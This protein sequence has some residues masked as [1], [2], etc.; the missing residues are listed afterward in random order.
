LTTVAQA[1]EED[2]AEIAQGLP[3]GLLASALSLAG[4]TIVRSNLLDDLRAVVDMHVKATDAAAEAYH[5][6]VAGLECAVD[7][8][9]IKRDQLEYDLSETN[10]RYREALDVQSEL[11]DRIDALYELHRSQREQLQHDLDAAEAK[12]AL[13]EQT[14]KEIEADWLYRDEQGQ[15]LHS[16]LGGGETSDV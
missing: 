6:R 13:I 14:H 5:I 12:I 16:L 8:A 15:H 9:R 1:I 10:A 7:A 11:Q 4:M 3:A 2:R